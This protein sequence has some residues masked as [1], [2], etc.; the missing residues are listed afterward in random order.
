MGSQAGER[1]HTLPNWYDAL[2]LALCFSFRAREF[3]AWC[4][5]C[6]LHFFRVHIGTLCLRHWYDEG[7]RPVDS[8]VQEPQPPRELAWRRPTRRWLLGNRQG[9]NILACYRNA[10]TSITQQGPESIYPPRAIVF[11]PSQ[12]GCSCTWLYGL[13]HTRLHTCT[14]C[15]KEIVPGSLDFAILG[16][17]IHKR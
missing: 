2:A 17:S 10:Y 12:V 1:G 13:V 9:E 3:P 7:L 5:P 8:A 14:V 15:T 16:C 4:T 11:V 6:S